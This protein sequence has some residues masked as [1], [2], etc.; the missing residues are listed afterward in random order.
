MLI[1][2]ISALFFTAHKHKKHGMLQPCDTEYPAFVY[3]PSI[4]ETNGF[5]SCDG[6]QK[7]F[8]V[9]QIANSNLLMLITEAECDCSIFPP[10]TLQAKESSVSLNHCVHN[11]S[12]KCERMRSQKT[13]KRPDT[14]HSFHPE[15]IMA[16]PLQ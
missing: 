12:V 2:L 1:L 14:C 13:R 15:V 5:I 3:E 9:Q 16:F 6:C 10:V 11:A 8:V 7:M 4:K